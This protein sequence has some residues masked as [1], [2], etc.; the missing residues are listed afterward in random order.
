MQVKKRADL[1]YER[2]LRV[3]ERVKEKAVELRKELFEFRNKTLESA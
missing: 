2:T 1:V 3:K